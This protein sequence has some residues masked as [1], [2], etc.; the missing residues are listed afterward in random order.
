MDFIAGIFGKSSGTK[1]VVL[2]DVSAE[3]IAGAYAISTPA[4]KLPVVLYT[5][6]FPVE[7]RAWEPPEKAMLRAVQ[8]LAETLIREGAP[9][10]LRATGSGKADAILV[11]IGAPWQKTSVRTEHIDKKETFEFTDDI[12]QEVLKE[13]ATKETGKLLVNESVIGTILNGYETRNPYGMTVRNAAIVVLTSFVDEQVARDV[14][15]LLRG[16]YHSEQIIPIAGGSLRCQ[17]V[18]TVFPHEHDVLII[19][20]TGSSTTIALVRRGLFVAVEEV[21]PAIS[22]EQWAEH[23]AENL[24]LLGKQYPLPRTIFLLA[25]EAE[26]GPLREALC[27]AKLEKLW[28]SDNPPKIVSVLARHIVGLVRHDTTATPDL[29]MILM[30][31]FWHRSLKETA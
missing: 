9:F 6:R 23:T 24:T 3:S 22:I 29:L 5:R 13:T 14:V 25:R 31:L 19:D 10:L 12:I 1:S 15:S 18:H 8:L 17:T 4:N 20:A 16:A 21:Q 28:L 11:A 2:I 7:V 30:T 26:I 27:S